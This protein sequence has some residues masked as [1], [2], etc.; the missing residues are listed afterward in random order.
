[1][2]QSVIEVDGKRYM[3]TKSA[4]QLWSLKQRDVASYCRQGRIK[5]AFKDTSGKWCVPINSVK[6]LTD[7][8]IRKILRLTLQL[9]NNPDQSFD[10]S[11]I[12]TD[13][14]NLISAYDYLA[15]IGYL[16]LFNKDDPPEEI[17]RKVEL[18]EK[19]MEIFTKKGDP[20]KRDIQIT[21]NEWKQVILIL[22]AAIMKAYSNN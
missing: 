15:S 18:T 10:L 5:G 17:P 1:M 7:E 13:T 19:G 21:I 2:R 9:K 11:T 14:N 6:P 22:I 12:N 16:K 4:A 8:H 20:E 3:N